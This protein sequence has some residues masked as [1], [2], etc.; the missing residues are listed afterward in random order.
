VFWAG[1]IA[2]TMLIIG[3]IL[4]QRGNYYAASTALVGVVM[5]CA[6]LATSDYRS[7]APYW[8]IHGIT[9]CSVL[10]A[11]MLFPQR[12]AAV[13]AAVLVIILTLLLPLW[14]SPVDFST[15]V[16]P[17]GTVC[18][19]FYFTFLYDNHRTQLEKERQEQLLRLIE[20]L[21]A[22]KRLAEENSRL[23]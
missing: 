10:L 12:K 19:I 1:V 14:T 20:D 4:S 18:L 22:A 2:T 17:M 16:Y 11:T 7:Y 8:S 5:I 9:A 3:Y 15:A 6:Y 13:I 23:K 21:Q